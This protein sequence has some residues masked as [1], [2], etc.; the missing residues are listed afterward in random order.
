M[1]TLFIQNK[2]KDKECLDFSISSLIQM[3]VNMDC[4]LVKN[5]NGIYL[6]YNVSNIDTIMD[7]INQNDDLPVTHK[8]NYIKGTECNYYLV[9]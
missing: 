4:K 6:T 2:R 8:F 5:N 9:F 3:R 1:I 7:I